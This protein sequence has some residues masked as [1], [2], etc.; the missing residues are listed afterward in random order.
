MENGFRNGVH[1]TT[2]GNT[3]G[4]EIMLFVDLSNMYT[5][6]NRSYEEE[7]TWSAQEIIHDAAQR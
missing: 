4:C 5:Q 2:D 6:Y 3:D 7:A 1:G